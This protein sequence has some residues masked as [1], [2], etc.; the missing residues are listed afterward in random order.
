MRAVLLCAYA[1]HQRRVLNL[2]ARL[3]NRRRIHS[4]PLHESVPS[5]TIAWR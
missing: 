2:L 5:S 4:V 3:A 1:C